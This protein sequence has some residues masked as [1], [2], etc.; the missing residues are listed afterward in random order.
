[1]IAKFPRK[2]KMPKLGTKNVLFGY[3]SIAIWKKYCLTWNQSSWICLAAKFGANLKTF[4]GPKI[5]DLGIFG[6]EF[7]NDI[8]IFEIREKMQM[9][10][11]G[12]KKTLFGYF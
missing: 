8:V 7:E 11:F 1:M 3:F 2:M 10:K 12:T 6:L 9:P 5:S 4:L